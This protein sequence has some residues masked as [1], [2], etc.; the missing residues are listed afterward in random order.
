MT[1]SPAR[2]EKP[3]RGPRPPG[4]ACPADAKGQMAYTHLAPIH[5]AAFPWPPGCT[6]RSRLPNPPARA[7]RSLPG[8][9]RNGSN[10]LRTRNRW[11]K[12]LPYN[13]QRRSCR[14][15]NTGCCHTRWSSRSCSYQSHCRVTMLSPCPPSSLPGYRRSRCR[16]TRML[17]ARLLAAATVGAPPAGP[18]DKRK[19]IR[20]VLDL[21]AHPVAKGN[22]CGHTPGSIFTAQRRSPPTTNRATAWPIPGP[23]SPKYGVELVLKRGMV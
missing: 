21:N 10:R 14:R 2:H 13:C 22:L 17:L 5:P 11:R 4:V 19:L 23:P 1:A 3:T 8:A 20:I 12:R 16:D 15:W 9:M 7:R 6:A 18:D